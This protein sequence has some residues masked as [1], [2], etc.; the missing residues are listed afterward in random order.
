VIK[1]RGPR[2]S[3]FLFLLF[4]SFIIFCIG[5][6]SG[7]PEIP[8]LSPEERHKITELVLSVAEDPEDTVKPARDE[9]W[10]ILGNYGSVSGVTL[11]RL[12]S[13]FMMIGEGHR[14]FWL[15]AREALKNHRPVKSAER[16]RWEERLTREGWLSEQQRDRFDALMKK[17]VD[18]EPIPSNHGVEVSLSATMVE[19]IVSSWDEQELRHSVEYLL[20]PP[21]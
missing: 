4:G 10:S 2:P 6:R 5:C 19:E 8:A 18:E 20:R 16:A 11:G 9:L 15:D 17:V 7:G 14:L 1:R 13:R 12:Q 3:R 21:G